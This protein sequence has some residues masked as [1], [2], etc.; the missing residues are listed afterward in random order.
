VPQGGT[1]RRADRKM[2]NSTQAGVWT[3]RPRTLTRPSRC[4]SRH[5]ARGT[6]GAGSAAAP[7]TSNALAQRC[8][9]YSHSHAPARRP[10]DG[11][12]APTTGDRSRHAPSTYACTFVLESLHV[13][14]CSG[15]GRWATWT[16][17]VS[18]DALRCN[19][20]ACTPRCARSHIPCR[21]PRSRASRAPTTA[22]RAGFER[23]QRG[24]RAHHRPGARK[25]ARS[26]PEIE[27]RARA[28]LP[29]H[30][31]PRPRTAPVLRRPYRHTYPL[32]GRQARA[33]RDPT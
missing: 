26:S 10:E 29:A 3:V 14:R 19:D 33:A 16:V 21:R 8:P 9:G 25:C 32:R 15:Y 1:R 4:S 12:A 24:A 22:S 7:A 31:P 11:V 28:A 23:K 27:V 20:T 17:H 18:R 30:A 2:Y 6:R 5:R 13:R